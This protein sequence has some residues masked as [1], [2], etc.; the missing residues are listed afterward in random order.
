MTDIDP[1]GAAP[2][3][4]AP[5][6]SERRLRILSY[7][8]AREFVRIQDLSRRFGVSEVT[9]RSDVDV[10]A[11]D[12][13]VRRVRGGV[14]RVL[15]AV[16][17][18]RYEARSGSFLKEKQA[19]GAAAAAM[20]KNGDS[21]VLDAGT[22]T[23][24][25]AHAIADRSDLED[26]TVFAAGLNVALALERAIPRIQ[27]IVTGGTLR[28]Q[29]HSLVEPMSTLILDRIRA[30]IA[31][32][33]CNGLDPPLGVMAMSPP[34]AALKQAIIA[35]AHC[36]VVVGDASKFSQT[37]LVKVCPFDE[38]DMILTAGT[39]DAGNLALIRETGVEVRVAGES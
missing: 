21:V 25:I 24:A 5:A 12:G 2:I 28:P 1:T 35:A 9:I 13:G 27:V 4:E 38:I 19:I 11:R 15:E 22:T 17:E 6:S 18:M 7:V 30:T 10:L 29:Q 26:V 37:A 3:A 39:P 33:G 31:F 23:M 20:L 14:M 32:I 8:R 16:P 36:N 34:D